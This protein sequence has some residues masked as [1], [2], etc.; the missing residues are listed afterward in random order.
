MIG[1]LL[2]GACIFLHELGH[3]L[4]AKACK[5]RVL[6]FSIGMGPKLLQFHRGET[7][8]SI[9][10]LPIGGF[11]AFEGESGEEPEAPGQDEAAGADAPAPPQYDERSFCRQPAWKRL[12]VLVMG[13]VMNIVFGLVLMAVLL[14]PQEAFAS[15][16]ISKFTEHSPM[17][18]AGLLPGDRFVSIDGYNI[19]TDMDIS[20]ALSLADPD[21]VDLVVDRG[22]QTLSFPDLRLLSQTVDGRK[23]VQMDFYVYPIERTP[24][25]LLQKTFANT[26][27][28]ERMVI[29]TLKGLLTGQFGLNDVAGP[30][31]MAQAITQSASAGLQSGFGDAVSNIVNAI[32]IITVNLGIANL[33]PIPAL[34]GGKILFLLIELIR[35]KPLRY[36]TQ[37]V[38][39]TGF[40]AAL[41]GFM[42]IVTISDVLRL[43]TGTGLGG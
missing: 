30:V 5:I 14:A 38:V 27:S 13:G 8:Y 20:V 21:H 23:M 36:K 17:Q 15:T 24:G 33:L 12:L 2:F 18:A 32:M 28:V 26:Y 41:I 16:T 29:L 40:M 1:V 39:E 43:A 7:A 37:T 34:D 25:A 10:A 9:R 6:E 3:F 11:C 35:R 22:G 31:G 4:S 19:H 42:V